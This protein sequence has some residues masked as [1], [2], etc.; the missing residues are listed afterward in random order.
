[1]SSKKATHVGQVRT[2]CGWVISEWAPS[3]QRN[4]LVTLRET[5]TQFIEVEIPFR[6]FYKKD[7]LQVGDKNGGT[8]LQIDT[9]RSV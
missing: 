8:Y 6:A 2:H 3:W 1:M 7:G 4:R 5:K 9:V